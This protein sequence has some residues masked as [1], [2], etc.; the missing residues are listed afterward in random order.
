MASKNTYT[1]LTA[2]DAIINGADPRNDEELM[3]KL[4]MMRA[5][6]TK[7]REAAKNAPRKP[8]KEAI[9]NRNLAVAMVKAIYDN[10]NEPVTAS[11]V[12]SHVQFLETPNKVGGKAKIAKREGWIENGARDGRQTTYVVTQAGIDMLASLQQ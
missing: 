1:N 10:G 11:W 5:S 4:K 8:S 2:L 7:K 6:E 12:S 9:A 3:T